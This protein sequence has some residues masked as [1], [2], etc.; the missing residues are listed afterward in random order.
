MSVILEVLPQLNITLELYS[1]KCI[2]VFG[3][4]QNFKDVLMQ[5]GG[6]FN[7][8]LKGLN[9][10]KRP[11]WVFVKSNDIANK[12]LQALQGTNNNSS[13]A[14][15]TSVNKP[16]KPPVLSSSSLAS[17]NPDELMKMVQ[18]LTKRLDS[19][20]T[21]LFTVR[22]LLHSMQTPARTSIQSMSTEDNEMVDE[23][24]GDFDDDEDDSCSYVQQQNK[25]SNSSPAFVSLLSKSNKK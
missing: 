20:E 6:K 21:E 3:D 14:A 22:K 17:F 24:I 2:A 10:T 4:T 7:P 19:V 15:A 12:I 13:S 18:Q 1:E 16:T 23:S 8:M 25:K 9:D 11:G 5:L